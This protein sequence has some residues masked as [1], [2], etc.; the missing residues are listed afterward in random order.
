MYFEF[1]CFLPSAFFISQHKIPPKWGVICEI[2]VRL[3]S[4]QYLLLSAWRVNAI[5]WKSFKE[6][7]IK[8]GNVWQQKREICSYTNQNVSENSHWN[9]F[10]IDCKRRVLKTYSRNIDACSGDI[11]GFQILA[12]LLPKTKAKHIAKA[13]RHIFIIKIS[14]KI[15]PKN[16]EWLPKHQFIFFMSSLNNNIFMLIQACYH[17]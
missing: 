6:Y 17:K 14:Y 8:H 1:K 11:S 10:P 12:L 4:C 9:I 5:S 16:V 2:S 3:L 13:L 15:D 7:V